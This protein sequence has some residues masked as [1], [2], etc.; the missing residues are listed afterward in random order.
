MSSLWLWHGMTE[1]ARTPTQAYVRQMFG[2][3]ADR[4]DL[5]NRVMTLWQDQR[6]RRQAVEVAAV[7]PGAHA[8]DVATGTGDLAVELARAVQSDGGVIGIDFSEPMLA[9]ARRK[10]TAL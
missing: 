10:A 5:M 9:Q 1:P 6:W 3:I 8:L 4:Y 7:G 2:A